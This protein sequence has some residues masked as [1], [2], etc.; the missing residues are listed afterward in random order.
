MGS[1][2]KPAWAGC[3]GCSDNPA[4]EFASSGLARVAI[5]R[6]VEGMERA[7]PPRHLDHGG[8]RRNVTPEPVL[9]ARHRRRSLFGFA[10][11]YSAPTREK[12]KDYEL[13]R[14]VVDVLHEVGR[15]TSSTST[16]TA[17][18]SSSRT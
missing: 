1:S 13:V 12:D 8:E 17:N 3:A 6:P 11:S 15:S 14:L 10:V 5:I 4:G 18:A 9:A 7:G 16:R 2:V